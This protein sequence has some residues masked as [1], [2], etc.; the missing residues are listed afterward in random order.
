M[1]FKAERPPSGN[2]VTLATW[3]YEQ[4]QRIAQ[5]FERVENVT[6]TELHSAPAR[7]INGTVVFADGTDW[8]PGS[9]RG[10]Y[11]YDAISDTWV[12]L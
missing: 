12:Q 2:Q 7:K 4:F 5:S 10:L 6:L 8:N 11:Y 1:A 9:G 3:L